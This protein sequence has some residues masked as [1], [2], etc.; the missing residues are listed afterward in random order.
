MLKRSSRGCTQFQADVQKRL[1]TNIVCNM[2]CC[3]DN[4]KKRICALNA[5][6]ACR[7]SLLNSFERYVRS[8]YTFRRNVCRKPFLSNVAEKSLRS[9]LAHRY[10]LNGR[11][12]YFYIKLG[13]LPIC[14]PV[15]VPGSKQRSYWAIVA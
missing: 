7:K 11:S 15:S 6:T 13:H 14:L 5:R 12:Q 10:I 9:Y 1:K 3:C 4:R 8:A 2:P